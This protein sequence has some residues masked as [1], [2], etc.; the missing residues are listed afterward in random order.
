VNSGVNIG[1][2]ENG[3]N[4]QGKEKTVMKR[5]LV[6][7]LAL[8]LAVSLVLAGCGGNGQQ[9]EEEEEEEAPTEVLLGATLPQTGIFAGFGEQG[10]GMQKAVDDWNDTY[11]GMELS[12]WGVTVPVRL[13]IKNNESNFDLAGPQSTELVVTDGVHALLSP[14]APSDLHD[15]TS[16]VANQYGVPSIICG[17]PLEP[18]YYGMRSGED[19]P[20]T[21]FHGFAIGDP[22]LPNPP[23]RDVPGYTMVDTWFMYMDEVGALTNTNGIAG[24]FASS[25][26]DGVGWY[27]SFPGLMEGYGLTVVGVEE[28]LGLFPMETTDYS[29]IVTA[30]KDADVEII[31]GNCPGAHFGDLF[32]E[33]YAQGFRPK[34]AMVARAALFPVDVNTWGTDPPL[35][36]GIG[37]EVWWSPH[38]EAADGFEGIGDRTAA[39]LAAD[40]DAEMGGDPLNR[41]IGSGY[42]GAQ[43]MLNAIHEAGDVDGDAINAV[44]ADIELNTIK[45]WVNFD[46]DTHFSAC[47][48]SFG[49]WFYDDVEEE[50]T[51][52]IVASALDIIAEEQE[53]LFPIDELYS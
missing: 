38:Y 48:L 21:W 51:L 31:W 20:Y 7:L 34:I 10:F 9:E 43:V 36:W 39:S 35:G 8:A 40:W 42:M 4:L 2:Q 29:S 14:D 53:P 47:P 33:C 50:F 44:L 32:S 28:E 23:P 19:W 45:G 1:V 15:P 46:S 11:G 25:D 41:S 27:A 49:Q 30:W 3:E 18:W 26:S 22:T 17:G 6:I 24:V 16:V 12:E 37:T 13:V 5:F 52:Y